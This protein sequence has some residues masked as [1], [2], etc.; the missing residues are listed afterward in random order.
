VARVEALRSV[1]CRPWNE[2]DE[3]ALRTSREPVATVFPGIRNQKTARQQGSALRTDL[4]SAA[5]RGRPRTYPRLRAAALL[6]RG[7][8]YATFSAT[9][10]GGMLH[11]CR[12][13][14]TIPLTRSETTCT[15]CVTPVTT[16]SCAR[17]SASL[18]CTG[19]N[20][21]I[22]SPC[23]VRS[24]R[25]TVPAGSRNNRSHT[26]SAPANRCVASTW[27]GWR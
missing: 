7:R 18:G 22:T 26:R 5:H 10:H 16:A 12:L 24:S 1:P 14:R 3:I 13:A 17:I 20:R 23:A 27:A 9:H 8:G 6:D 4:I 15:P 11:D 21:Q 25:S 2:R 19:A